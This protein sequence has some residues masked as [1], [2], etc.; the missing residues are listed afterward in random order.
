MSEPSVL[1]RAL[2]A[3]PVI[4]AEG[5]EFPDLLHRLSASDILPLH[6]GVVREAIL[7]TEKG[8]TID[9]ALALGGRGVVRILGS[10]GSRD[11]LLAWF[12]KYTIMEDIRYRDACNGFVQWGLH[13]ATPEG[14]EAIPLPAVRSWRWSEVEIG[15]VPVI[16][17]RHESVCGPGARLLFPT[18]R[19]DEA[20][21]A[22]R[23]FASEHG[24]PLVSEAGF[25]LWRIR[26]GFPAVGF[27]LTER[28]N[29]LE[30]GAGS[31]VSFSKGCYIGQEVIARLDSYDKV[32]RHLRAM[33]FDG[34]M[35]EGIEPGTPLLRDG[36]NAGFLTSAAN[37]PESGQALALAC[38]RIGDEAEG[39]ALTAEVEG[40]EH[41]GMVLPPSEARIPAE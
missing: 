31:A 4:E 28:T 32:Q 19:R 15:G 24:I 14:M 16:L 13:A 8:R 17:A 39:T 33:R 22:M 5:V 6:D 27:E 2:P 11:A 36:R 12:G 26:R 38:V 41:R 40:R 10:P 29:P 18:E 37:D 23:A 35:P 9:V 21:A 7:T 30:S 3:W 20:D 34:P 25:A 1:V